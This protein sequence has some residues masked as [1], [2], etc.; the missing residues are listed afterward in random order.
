MS[1]RFYRAELRVSGDDA[2]LD[3]FQAHHLAGGSFSFDTV[4]PTP[5]ELLYDLNNF[6]EDGYQAQ[7]GD[8]TQLAS[9]WM[10][11]PHATEAG[12]PF[13]LQSREQVLDCLLAL[14]DD[15]LVRLQLGKLYQS[16]LERHGFGHAADW[17][18]QHWGGWSDAD[19]VSIECAAEGLTIYFMT[20]G[21]PPKKALAAMA[22]QHP[23]LGFGLE[24]QDDCGGPVR[25][26]TSEAVRPAR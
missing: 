7:F 8:W 20:A 5:P 19:G 1:Q 2:A 3:Q 10:F 26:W 16:N 22:K 14:G 15:G 11:K 4:L 25:R 24:Y 18:K 21:P 9:R 13:P 12:Y 23:A 17:R 6:V